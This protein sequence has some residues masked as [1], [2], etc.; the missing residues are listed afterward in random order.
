MKIFLIGF[1]GSGKSTLGKKLALKLGYTFIDIDKVIENQINMSISEY[2]QKNG[3]D[4][5]RELESSILKTLELPENTIIAT[6]GGAPCF[7]DN[8]Q[9]MNENGTT[10]YLSLSPN[11]LAKRLES[12]TEQR[13]VLQNLKGDKL[14][15]FIA[16]KL[17]LREKFYTQAEVIVKGFDQTPEKVIEILKKANYLK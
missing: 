15:Q 16:E 6:G 12:A 2:F 8:L 10:I 1:M 13:P 11:A 7:Y 4:S 5:F 14:E 3:E 9:W 17:Q